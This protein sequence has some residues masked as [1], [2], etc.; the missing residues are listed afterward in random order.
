MLPGGV[1]QGRGEMRLGAGGLGEQPA[2]AGR[3]LL[4]PRPGRRV[5]SGQRAFHERPG[6]QVPLRAGRGGGKVGDGQVGDVVVQRRAV[7]VEELAEL[8]VGGH[9]VALGQR[10]DACGVPGPGG[11]PA[12]FGGVDRGEGAGQQRRYPVVVAAH[13]EHGGRGEVGGGGDG[14]HLVGGGGVVRL[15]GGGERLVPSP[16][17]DVCPF[18]RR[19]HGAAGAADAGRAQLAEGFAQHPDREFGLVQDPGR[20]ADLAPVAE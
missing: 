4:Q 15:A 7:G 17:V 1:G 16:A 20:R 8:G 14:F 18:Q 2:G 11:E 6:F 10:G 5:H 12:V 9:V 3:E 13:G 19:E